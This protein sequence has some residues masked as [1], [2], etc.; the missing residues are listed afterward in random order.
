MS[1]ATLEPAELDRP[2]PNARMDFKLTN[3][4]C[5]FGLGLLLIGCATV[6]PEDDEPP[7]FPVMSIRENKFTFDKFDR[8]RA[9][10]AGSKL[11]AHA[12]F[13]LVIDR[14]GK[15]VR[16]RTFR[17]SLD[18]FDTA[19]FKSHV[20]HMSFTPAPD[21]DPMPFRTLFYMLK[22]QHEWIER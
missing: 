9:A 3:L 16:I 8:Q 19:A 13:E 2:T 7:S 4:F 15:V 21:T 22:T 11:R 5:I 1:L 20:Q 10:R 14:S 6:P 12:V 17:S 18:D